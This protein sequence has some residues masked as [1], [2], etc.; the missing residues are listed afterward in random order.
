MVLIWSSKDDAS[1]AKAAQRKDE[2]ALD[3]SL[4][5]ATDPVLSLRLMNDGKLVLSTGKYGAADAAWR[6]TVVSNP[7]MMGGWRRSYILSMGLGAVEELII[8]PDW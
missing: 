1:G 7:Y 2:P 5:A 8:D 4:G 6:P 3:E